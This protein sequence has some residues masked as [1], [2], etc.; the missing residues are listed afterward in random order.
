MLCAVGILVGPAAA[1]R[2]LTPTR[3][4][5]VATGGGNESPSAWFVELASPPSVKGT[6][7]ATLKAEHDAFKAN[8]AAQGVKVTERY[9]FSTLFN[10]FSVSV[11]RS[12]AAALQTIPGVKAV[13]P[14]QQVSIGPEPVS[15][16]N[17]ED[18]NSNPMIGADIAQNEL[19]FDGHGVKIAIMDSGVDYT[20]PELGGCFGPG[21]KVAKGFDFVGDNFDSN[22]AD[23]TFNPV[24]QPDND[25][26]P[27][28]PNVA[29]AR[30]N[31]PRGGTSDA[32]HGTHVAGI[33]AADGRGHPG[34]VTG[35]APGATIYAYRVFGCNGSTDDDTMIAAMERT[36]AD[37]AQVLNMSIGSAFDT[38]PE[39]P[40]A[41]AATN[42][43]NAGV[44]VVASYGNSG[45]NGLYSG[46]AP[47]VGTNV[48]GVASVDN[49]KATGPALR[50]NGHLFAYTVAAGAPEPPHSGSFTILAA[51]TTNKTGCV[52]FPSGLFAGKIALIQR[53]TCT[54]YTKASNA[55]A[56]GAVGVVLFNNVA[57]PV[58][59]TVA[60]SPP[61]TI[62]VVIISKAD[63]DSV[64]TAALAG[65]PFEWTNILVESP[66]A[67]AGLISDFSSYGTDA[68]LTLKPDVSAP[69][70]QIFS[71]WPHQQF[72]GHN[73][74]S[75]TSMAAP[76][77]AGAAALYLQAHPDASVS[78]VTTALMNTAKPGLWSLAPQ[79][80]LL[81]ETYR[82]GAGL[83]QIADAITSP[84]SVTPT[85]ISLGE[86]TGGTRTLTIHNGGS[87]PVT[88]D[89]S[90]LDAVSTGANTFSLSF[91]AG[92]NNVT[93][94]PSSVTVA[95]GGSANATVTIGVDPTLP[96]GGLYD[97]YLTLTPRGGGEVLH[98][99]WAGFK[100][101]YQS[102]K[103]LTD[104]SCGLPALFQLKSSGSDSCLG[105]G[106][107]RIGNGGA[108]FTMQGSDI[109]IVL[110]HLN[111]QARKLNIQVLNADGSF[112]QPVF[113]YADKEVFLPRNSTSTAFFEFDWDGTRGQDNGNN[114]RKVLPN[115]TYT[116]KLS[117]LK[118]LGNENNP[119]DWETWT[120]PAFT[121]ARP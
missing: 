120:S 36:L 11:P 105:G 104:A 99:P 29:D 119:A 49:T 94:S 98:V 97:G 33:A 63:G 20:L 74:I 10:G 86:G 114:K 110:Y 31:Q 13:Y 75:G 3:P 121:I 89:L 6:S 53:G 92:E 62:P 101:D 23:S 46:G 107:Q 88:Y 102:I 35:V 81:D 118:A 16:G 8:A 65:V 32:G 117:V 37:G 1:S 44:V 21:C 2:G 87:T 15:Q 70:G 25:P 4:V 38:W 18:T 41:Q 28:D 78:T 73:T 61:I 51:P 83:I 26:A 91:F 85:K 40:T 96:D 54:F 50:I 9:S 93:F 100:G 58:S 60:G 112:V 56:A 52:A 17:P 45:A 69:G 68:E 115:G 24:R 106:I 22:P 34:E 109:P 80:G 30:A 42:L 64:Y 12:Q 82:Q 90:N 71:T 47:G 7:A 66:L 48:I 57:A 72:G 95:A 19:G 113:N 43:A 39:S 76:H 84:A 79:F 77:V 67:T 14:V 116:L 108:T 27:C 111:H 55:M 103:V 59:P 5:P